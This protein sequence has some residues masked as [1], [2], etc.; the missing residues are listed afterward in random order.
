M[1]LYVA[2]VNWTDQ[3]IKNYRD[4][5]RGRTGSQIQ[6]GSANLSCAMIP[7]AGLSLGGTGTPAMPGNR[8]SPMGERGRRWTSSV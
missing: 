5:V 4:S 6:A 2:L 1:P 8:P 7:M 3:G